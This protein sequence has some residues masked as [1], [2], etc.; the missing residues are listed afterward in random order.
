M[1]SEEN[2]DRGFGALLTA[3]ARDG[4]RLARHEIRL[5]RLEA[6]ARARRY[7]GGTLMIAAGVALGTIG[8]VTAFIGIVLLP[9]DQWLRDRYWLAALIVTVV[10]ALVAAW[11]ARRGA[12]FLSPAR[13]VP[14]ETVETLK[15]DSE[16]VRRQLRR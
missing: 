9:G 14:D 12:A 3:L 2:G 8:L 4:T 15:E 1:R 7:G 10:T 16:W 13:L 6:G 11:C 5:V